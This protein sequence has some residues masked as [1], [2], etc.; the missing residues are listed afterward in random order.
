M[1]PRETVYL[2]EGSVLDMPN[3][4]AMVAGAVAVM[5]PAVTGLVDVPVLVQARVR[6]PARVAVLVD[7]QT[8][9][10][11]LKVEPGTIVWF[12]FQGSDGKW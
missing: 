5:D 6:A 3:A 9:K 4:V 10:K 11:V 1:R 2:I 12:H 8:G 7:V